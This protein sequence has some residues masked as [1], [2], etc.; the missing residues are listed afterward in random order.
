M[1]SLN[2]TCHSS[3]KGHEMESKILKPLTRG[4]L[5]DVANSKCHQQLDQI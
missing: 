4:K 5:A 1:V 2:Q 3:S